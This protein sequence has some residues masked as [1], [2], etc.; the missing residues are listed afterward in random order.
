MRKRRAAA[1]RL[2]I[3]AASLVSVASA[4]AAQRTTCRP[5]LL[6]MTTPAMRPPSRTISIGMEA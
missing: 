1:G 4:T 3:F 5:A 6:A 2:H